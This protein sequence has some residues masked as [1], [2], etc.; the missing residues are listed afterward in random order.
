MKT[1]TRVDQEV[2]E[3]KEFQPSLLPSHFIDAHRRPPYLTFTR[4]F[5]GI[6]YAN[7][8]ENEVQLQKM[9]KRYKSTLETFYALFNFFSFSVFFEGFM[10]G[11]AQGICGMFA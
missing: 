6:S 5:C 4:G 11:E 10:H 3:R 8:R 9:E 2:E 1:S 7:G